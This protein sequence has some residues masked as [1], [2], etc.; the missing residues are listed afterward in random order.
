[1]EAWREG[2]LKRLRSDEGWLTVAGLFWLK[3]GA[4][5]FGSAADNPVRLPAHSAPARGRACCSCAAIR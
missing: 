4:N 1:M 2:R 5:A 3:P